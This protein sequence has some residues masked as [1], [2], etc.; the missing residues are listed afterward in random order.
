MNKRILF[1][2]TDVDYVI[3]NKTIIRNKI[4]QLIHLEGFRLNNINI[5]ICSDNYLL[6]INKEH[7]GHN[8][9]TDVITFDLSDI[10]EEIE[11]DIYISIDRIKEN[12]KRFSVALNVEFQRVMIHGVLHLIGYDDQTE[13]DISIMRKKEN[14]YLNY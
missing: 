8:Y 4:A 7:L 3:P 9:F 11:G 10:S 13:K 6:K 12:K 5:I 1:H 2:Q 14:T